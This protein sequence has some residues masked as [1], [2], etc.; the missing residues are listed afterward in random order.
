M[1]TKSRRRGG[2]AAALA[3]FLVFVAFAYGRDPVVEDGGVDLPPIPAGS[4]DVS[5]KPSRVEAQAASGPHRLS[6]PNGI[7]RYMSVE[8]PVAA[9]GTPS[10]SGKVV[11]RLSTRTPEGTTN[12][13]L[14][15][16]RVERGRRLWIQARLPV[17]P[18]NTLGWIPRAA[19]GGYNQVSTRLV[20][21][22]STFK[23]TLYR[24]GK[25]IW[26]ARVGVGQ[27]RWP[28]PIGEFYIRNRLT[29]YSSPTYG[30][31]AFGT[32]ARSATLTDWPAGGFVGIHGTNQPSLIPGRI[33]HGC[34][35]LRNA[36]ILR[37]D[38]LMPPGTPLSVVR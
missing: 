4:E 16:R 24:H 32:S 2:F 28:T 35:R 1:T 21:R 6:N 20:V 36:D 27:R 34:I 8:Q 25:P 23:A 17:L 30:P 12:V 22:L 7:S 14:A 10:F 33:S 18:N 9:R 31:L 19:L 38:R 26:N 3:L 5:A 29:K 15:L 11:A 37:L 13:V